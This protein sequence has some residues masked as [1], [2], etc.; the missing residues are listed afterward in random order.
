MAVDLRPVG[1][2]RVGKID[3]V[4]IIQLDLS[5][6]DLFGALGPE[7]HVTLHWT[8]GPKDDSLLHF[9]RMMRDYHAFHKSK[10]WG[11][12]GYHYGLPRTTPAIVLLRPVTLKG[13]HVGGHNSNNVGIVCCGGAGGKHNRPPSENQVKALGVL[14]RKAHTS[15][16]PRPYRTDRPLRKPYCTRRAHKDWPGHESNACNGTYR[17]LINLR[18]K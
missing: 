3:G 5:F 15:K 4:Q 13:A 7:K 8:A 11:G 14:L 1:A 10:G 17:P 9:L 2:R 16:F 18:T 12:I 6:Q